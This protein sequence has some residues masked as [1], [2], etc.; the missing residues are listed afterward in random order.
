MN[1]ASRPA[2]AVANLTGWTDHPGD[3]WPDC[4]P[5]DLI[6]VERRNGYGHTDFACGFQWLSSGSPY[7]IIRYRKVTI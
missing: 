7:D 4:T 1:G 5:A 2:F 3:S 6:E